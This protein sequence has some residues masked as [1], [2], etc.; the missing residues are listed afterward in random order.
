MA[1]LHRDIAAALQKVL[2]PSTARLQPALVRD[3]WA[4]SLWLKT[5]TLL[6]TILLDEA[7][8]R[9]LAAAF[10]EIKDLRP[11]DNKLVVLH[12]PISGQTLVGTT[13]Y[14]FGLISKAEKRPFCRYL[15]VSGKEPVLLAINNRPPQVG[16][17]Q[18]QI[19]A[20]F[21]AGGGG[22]E[23]FA[24]F[25][26]L[27]LKENQSPQ[28]LIPFVGYYLDYPVAYSVG[29]CLTPA[30]QDVEEEQ[31]SNCLGDVDLTVFSAQWTEDDSLSGYKRAQDASPWHPLFSFSVP[32]SLL[33]SLAA[34]PTSVPAG[35]IQTVEEEIRELVRQRVR[36]LRLQAP[37][38]KL[39]QKWSKSVKVEVEVKSG[40]RLDRV[41]L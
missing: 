40:V 19:L 39:Q 38:G 34:R 11:K 35:E 33:P 16:D 41:A 29:E 22:M 9:A 26:L 7:Q 15:D 36:S 8:A 23:S 14:L 5:T 17:L 4:V 1:L 2:P 6:D 27:K 13:F 37:K 24:S 12:E 21:G 3:I 18:Y 31:R 28:A 30:I 10:D 20:T 25:I 32:T